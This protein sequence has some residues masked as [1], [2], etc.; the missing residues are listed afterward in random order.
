MIFVDEM[1]RV[2]QSWDDF[3]L[4]NQYEKCVIVAPHMGI[5]N[6][7][8]EDKVLLDT[9]MASC[10]LL[11]NKVVKYTDIGT[12]VT[13]L[14]ATGVVATTAVVAL[15]A[16]AVA[17]AVG[18]GFG[19][20]AYAIGRGIGKL[21]DRSS[22]EQSITLQEKESRG[23]WLGIAGGVV[24]VAAGAATKGVEFAA[25]NGQAINTVRVH[26]HSVQTVARNGKHC[27]F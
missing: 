26:I 13:G 23:I 18:T 8:D 21:M 2:Y 6:T 17:G 25:R 24:G 10:L 22:H 14:V 4:N 12:T 19:C 7:D 11:G 5:Y 27:I 3:K 15:P 9:F 20:A 16:L 1:A